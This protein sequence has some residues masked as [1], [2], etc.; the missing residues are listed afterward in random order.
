MPCAAK[1]ARGVQKGKIE[2]VKDVSKWV[3]LEVNTQ[4]TRHSYKLIRCHP[5]ESKTRKNYG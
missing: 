3:G 2:V 5:S 4:K 1:G